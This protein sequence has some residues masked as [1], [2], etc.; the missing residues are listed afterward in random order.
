M[1]VACSICLES[2]TVTSDIY[3]TPCG[4]VFHY[5]CI[6]KWLASG[7]Q[8]CSQCRQDCKI[9]DIVKLYFSENESALENNNLCTQLE[10]E[11]LKLQQEINVLKD[12]DFAANQKYTQLEFENLRL[13]QKVTKLKA[14]ELGTNKNCL[15]LKEENKTLHKRLCQGRSNS[16]GIDR[17]LK[18]Q[19]KEINNKDQ[20]I[21][22]LE[23]KC[24]QLEKAIH[25]IE[26][27]TKMLPE[28]KKSTEKSRLGI[29]C[30]MCNE[31]GHMARRC[32]SAGM[33][34]RGLGAFRG[35]PR[36]MGSFENY[37]DMT[38]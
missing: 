32:P 35:I 9:N 29:I 14:H 38:R 19:R 20:K 34:R 15:D 33:G 4:H 27:N 13:E 1:N 3:T 37:V 24:N 36:G 28:G 31:D 7:N 2:L 26:T 23:A 30:Y 18:E 8:H 21:S 17:V 16:A 10:S 5:D 22:E 12:R 11:N 6:Q 25:T